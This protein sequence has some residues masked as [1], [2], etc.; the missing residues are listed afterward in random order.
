MPDREFLEKFPLYR[1]FKM[2]LP[3]T[4]DNLGKPA[5]H[6]YCPTCESDQTFRMNNEYYDAFEYSNFP[7]KG[8]VV[9]VVYVCVSCVGFYR[10]FLLK[11]SPEGDYVMKVGQEPP[12]EITPDRTL[13]RILGAHA[14]YYKKG[15]VCESQSYGIGAFA[16][17]RRIV[18]EIIDELLES[19][20][21]LMA[22]EERERYLEALEKVKKTTV[23]QDKIDLVKDL[24]PPILRPGG[25][26]P[27]STL[28][29]VLSE[30]LHQE[31]D[32][33][34]IEL[35]MTVREV[36]VFLVNQVAITQAAAASFTESMRRLLDRKT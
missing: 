19:I 6:M 32:E 36:L 34:C 3:N 13:E 27:L 7:V 22:G 20:T 4:L 18:E 16:Y 11:F 14:E 23:T 25:M 5:I 26:N 24:L 1:K 30:G 28:H 10:Y 2:D 35:A 9:R 17:Y 12:W 29:S 33:R 15:L 31:S 21:D 8:T